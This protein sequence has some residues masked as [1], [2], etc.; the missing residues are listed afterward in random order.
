MGKMMATFVSVTT[1]GMQS[2]RLHLNLD[3][4]AWMVSVGPGATRIYFA[5]LPD[6]ERRLGMPFMIEVVESPDEIMGHANRPTMTAAH[7]PAER[8]SAR[9]T[10]QR[11]WWGRRAA[12]ERAP[13]LAPR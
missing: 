7:P 5:S 10:R 4:V 8:V 12:A 3:T 1:R 13:D 11:Q 9:Q 2:Q 6:S